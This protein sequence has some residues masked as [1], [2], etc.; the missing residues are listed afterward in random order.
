MSLG[1]CNL[2]GVQSCKQK[3]SLHFI[4]SRTRSVGEILGEELKWLSLSISRWLWLLSDIGKDKNETRGQ[5]GSHSTSY[6]KKGICLQSSHFSCRPLPNQPRRWKLREPLTSEWKVMG[7]CR[8]NSR[9]VA[10]IHSNTLAHIFKNQ[11]IIIILKKNNFCL[12]TSKMLKS[13]WSCWKKTFSFKTLSW[14]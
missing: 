6:D 11:T 4:L 3:F 12:L 13:T 10:T 14:A 1:K 2:G 5:Q 8:K 7:S 9:G